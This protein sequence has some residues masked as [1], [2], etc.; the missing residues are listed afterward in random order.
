MEK[1]VEIKTV[2]LIQCPLNVRAIS[3]KD[4]KGWK[5]GIQALAETMVSFDVIVPLIV[6]ESKVQQGKYEV[7]SG[8]RRRQAGNL[9]NMK[10]LPCVIRELDDEK[11]INLIAIEDAQRENFT[12]PERGQLIVWLK[13]GTLPVLAG[14]NRQPLVEQEHGGELLGQKGQKSIKEVAE[15]LKMRPRYVEAVYYIAKGLPEALQPHVVDPSESKNVDE[16]KLTLTKA[17]ELSLTLNNKGDSR[18]EEEKLY[19]GGKVISEGLDRASLRRTLDN[20]K[21]I[22]DMIEEVKRTSL[23]EQLTELYLKKIGNTW[24]KFDADPSEVK[25]EIDIALGRYMEEQPWDTK[26][27]LQKMLEKFLKDWES[28]NGSTIIKQNEINPS[29]LWTCNLELKWN[30]GAGDE[31]QTLADLPESMFANFEDADEWAMKHSGYAMDKGP[32]STGKGKVWRL[33]I[34][35]STL[36]PEET[37]KIL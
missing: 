13:D 33:M 3:R 9:K 28:L 12:I 25:K 19:I 30:M 10:T 24:G 32:V 5:I 29:G 17:E 26:Q 23:R 35:R 8:E 34:K 20:S 21:K 16:H 31:V 14:E 7:V 11:A 37:T 4:E 1:I 18:T 36:T 6:R 27:K 15:T 2:D 22:E